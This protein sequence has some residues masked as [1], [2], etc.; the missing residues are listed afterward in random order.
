MHPADR[1]DARI[2]ATGSLACVGLDPRP[3]LLPPALRHRAIASHG[4]GPDGV[5]EA[6][7]V[8]NEAVIDAVADAC[9]CVKPQA[10][11]YEAYGAAGWRALEQTAAYAE[12]A[13]VP[14]ILDAKRGDIGST[15]EHYGQMAFGGAPGLDDAPAHGIGAS[16]V[17]VNPY[18]G[19]DG[20]LPVLGDHGAGVFVLVR[21][22]NPSSGDLQ[23]TPAGEVT[24][25]ETVADL[26]HRW[27]TDRLGARG[28][29]DVGAVVGATYPEHARALRHRMPDTV[30]LV[31]GYGAQGA[32]AADALAGARGDGRG[33]VVSSSRDIIGAWQAAVTD[34]WGG[35]ARSAL[36]AMNRDLTTARR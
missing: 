17:T 7:R 8:F 36:D 9:A 15:A 12:S 33:V 21:T 13:G 6:F 28:L 24:V 14:V 29:S 19:A 31:P 35:A 25:A 11:C 34:D 30:F 1:L 16:W 23:D 32:S 26:V 4:P 20:V 10:A 22:S 5:A 2:E 18:L 27:G 3:T